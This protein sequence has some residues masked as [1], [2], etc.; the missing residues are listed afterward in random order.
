MRHPAR[1]VAGAIRASDTALSECGLGLLVCLFCS[2][3]A[4]NCRNMQ[5]TESSFSDFGTHL[6]H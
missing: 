1:E 2:H 5:I 6:G 4:P 3:V